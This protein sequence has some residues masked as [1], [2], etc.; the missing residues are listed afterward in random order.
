MLNGL[1]GKIQ[2]EKSDFYALNNISFKIQKGESVGILGENG[3]GKSTLLQII[4]NTLQ[5]VQEW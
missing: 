5:P 3:S 1:T 4:A 2:R